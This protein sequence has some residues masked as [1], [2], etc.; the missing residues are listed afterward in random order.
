MHKPEPRQH[1][2]AGRPVH[3][4]IVAIIVARL[5]LAESRNER[6]RSRDLPGVATLCPSLFLL[7]F[8][9]IRG[10]EVRVR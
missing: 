8:S 1:Q 9:L 6:S 4:N 2:V 7:V 10:T 5:R 3:T